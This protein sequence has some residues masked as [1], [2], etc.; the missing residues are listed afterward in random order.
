MVVNLTI[1]TNQ[2]CY[3]QYRYFFPPPLPLPSTFSYHFET[4][5][6]KGGF[7]TPIRDETIKSTSILCAGSFQLH[8]S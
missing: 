4:E 7:D 1:I 3:E 8:V 5:Y 2:E 6:Y